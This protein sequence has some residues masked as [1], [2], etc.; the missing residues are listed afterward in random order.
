VASVTRTKLRN[1]IAEALWDY[2]SATQLADVCDDLR[3]PLAPA[4]VHP[5]SSKRRYVQSRTKTYE[6]A[7]L[8]ATS[9]EVVL[10]YPHQD[11]V[12][13][14]AEI[15]GTTGGVHGELKNII[16]AAVGAKPQIVL[17]DA[18]NN[19]VDIVEGADR[20]LVYNAPLGEDGLSWRS[21]L[22]WSAQRDGVAVTDTNERDLAVA[23]FNRLARSVGSEPE[24]LML[25][26]YGTLYGERGFDLPA[27]L[28]QVYLHAQDPAKTLRSFYTQLLT[29]HGAVMPAGLTGRRRRDGSEPRSGRRGDCDGEA[30]RSM[31]PR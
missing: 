29:R 4:D 8:V 27:L 2:V 22:H 5:M 14:L 16:F 1:A 13:L 20:C 11:L 26:T 30:Q 18:L 10:D 15:D 19:D 17:R 9:R 23:L 25:R 24:L 28:P 3:M 6:M 31:L 12:A 7:Q 21:L